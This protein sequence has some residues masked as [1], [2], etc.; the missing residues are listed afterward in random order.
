ME[1]NVF[2]QKSPQNNR[3]YISMIGAAASYSLVGFAQVRLRAICFSCRGCL[4]NIWLLNSLLS[5]SGVG[6][7]YEQCYKS[8]FLLFASRAVVG[9]AKQSATLSK[10]ILSS[11]TTPDT[12]SK[13]LGQLQAVNLVRL[14]SYRVPQLTRDP[15]RLGNPT[16]LTWLVTMPLVTKTLGEI[17]ADNLASYHALGYQDARGNP[18][19]QLG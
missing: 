8:V 9:L 13:A 15:R 7:A 10:H 14:V 19:C 6:V 1:S 3:L 11:H 12:R 2:T 18:R 5:V 16:Q 4:R 17:R